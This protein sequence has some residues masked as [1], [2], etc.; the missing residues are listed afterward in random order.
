MNSVLQSLQPAARIRVAVVIA[1]KGRPRAL[2]ELL[3]LLECQSQPPAVVVISATGAADVE[4]PMPTTLNI[5][6]VYG[7]PGSAS[8]RNKGLELIDGRADVAVFFDDDFA[9]AENWLEECAG[10]FFLEPNNAG[11]NGFIVH[12]GAKG[13]PVSWQ[14]ARLL[15]ARQGHDPRIVSRI[16]DL[17]GCNMA[18]RMSAISELRF[19]ERL[20]LYGWLEDKDFSRQAGKKGDLVQCNALVGVHLGL[21]AGRVSGKRYGYSQVVNAWYL[22]RK[23]IMSLR[24]ASVHILKA[25]AANAAKAV[26]RQGYI[27]RRGRLRGNL[28]GVAHLL[29]GSCRPERVAQL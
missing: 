15:M 14:E 11:A 4:L 9:P 22:Y 3:R 19:D 23:G 1:T 8:Q 21:Q 5:E 29:S 13:E 6:C 2:V 12:D 24:E 28:I 20:V 17:Y 27:D 25:L 18:F 16:P 26:G 10:V 7:P